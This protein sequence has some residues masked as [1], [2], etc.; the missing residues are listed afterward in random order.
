MVE[1]YID[2]RDAKPIKIPPRLTPLSQRKLIESEINKM[3]EEDVIEPSSS[4]WSSPILIVTKKD[5][6]P[7][8]CLDNRGVNLLT[9]KDAYPLS[10]IVHP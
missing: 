10:R 4:P 3:L 2:T 6:T 1:H 5:G 7:R 9:R 8:F